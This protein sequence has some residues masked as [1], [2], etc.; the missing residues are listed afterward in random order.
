MKKY[1]YILIAL[2]AVVC[3]LVL[4]GASLV[5]ESSAGQSC[6]RCHEIQ[7]EYDSW[8]MS[9][10]RGVGCKSC[11]GET[12]TADVGFHLNNLHRLISH[13]RGDVPDVIHIRNIDVQTM[14][15]RCKSCHQQEFAQWQAGP[16]SATYARIFLDKKHNGKVI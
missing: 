8:H 13:L 7:K 6:T 4:P 16:H 9:T 5:Y 2:A 15:A 14:M 1:R 3:L 10:H 12:L 11:H